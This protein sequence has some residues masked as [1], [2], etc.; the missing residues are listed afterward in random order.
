MVDKGRRGARKRTGT[1]Y[2]GT[3]G[4]VVV[5]REPNYPSARTPMSSGAEGYGPIRVWH[6]AARDWELTK[7]NYF[8][9]EW[10]FGKE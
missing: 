1:D 6:S 2:L 8:W 4:C 7:S 9:N 3:I 10:D 5:L